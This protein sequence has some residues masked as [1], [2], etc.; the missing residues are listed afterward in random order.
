MLGIHCSAH[1]L[2]LVV[3]DS[4]SGEYLQELEKVISSILTHMSAL[5]KASIE[6][7]GPWPVP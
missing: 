1:K 5:K 2:Q 6:P 7:L 3:S 4:W